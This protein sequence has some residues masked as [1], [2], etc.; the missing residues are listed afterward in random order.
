LH[1]KIVALRTI[2]SRMSE[3]HKSG[4]GNEPGGVPTA[5]N[6]SLKVVAKEASRIATGTD[7]KALDKRIGIANRQR[8][9]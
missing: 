2:A 5:R 8:E 9:N 7:S 1:E 4:P 3:L 6:E